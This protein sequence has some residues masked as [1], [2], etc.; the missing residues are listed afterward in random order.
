MQKRLYWSIFLLLLSVFS[1]GGSLVVAQ[2]INQVTQVGEISLPCAL[3]GFSDSSQ[4]IGIGDLLR[5][6]VSYPFRLINSPIAIAR[7]TPYWIRL[8]V[9]NST[10]QALPVLIEA[11]YPGLN[12]VNAYVTVNHQLVQS[13]P[14]ESWRTPF[15]QRA[16]VHRTFL[17]PVTVP[18]GQ[19]RTIYLRLQRQIGNIRF[20]IRVWPTAAYHQYDL[21]Q[22][23]F[24]GFVSGWLLLAISFGLFLGR[25]HHDR[26]YFMYSAYV[27]CSLLMLLISKGYLREYLVE[28]YWPD[29]GQFLRSLS[30]L[31]TAVSNL[32]F[33]RSLLQ[34]HQY[35]PHWLFQLSRWLLV[36]VG[37]CFVL[38]TFESRVLNHL[39]SEMITL[40]MHIS[41]LIILS[42]VLVTVGFILYGIRHPA[43][44]PSAGLY[45]LAFVPAFLGVNEFALN[46]LYVTIGL[47]DFLVFYALAVV[48]ETVI[49]LLGLAYRFKT[50]RDERER[51]LREQSQ[52]ALRTQL[53][54]RERLARD[55]HDHIGPDL[56]A[57]KLRLEVARDETTEPAV[58]QTLQR[59]IEQTDRIVADI[60]QVSHALMPTGLRQQ[61]L[62]ISL[63]DYVRQVNHTMNGPEINFTHELD[64]QLPELMQQTLL[65][66]AKELVNNAL[67]HARATVID[68]ELYREDNT[69]VLTVSDNGRG[70]NPKHINYQSGGIGLR[71]IRTVV[72]GLRGQTVVSAKPT[73]GMVHQVVIP[74]GAG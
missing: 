17:F 73:G 51:L 35:A 14:R 9:A 5:T 25:I 65:S 8:T 53:T 71:N 6:R 44:R 55:L 30:I 43:S 10:H 60:R 2:H 45:L 61:G 7:H 32:F 70:Y 23:I 12:S 46:L 58:D 67:R 21:R 62:V 74:A 4:T 15:S 50:Y 16:I 3:Y 64:T 26:L 37:C 31:L 22:Q 52:L 27:S 39:N 11:D 54:E 24:W 57:L 47:F 40:V 13:F 1:L 18:P 29:Y 34:S 38:Y 66:A 20:P 63:T 28:A 42:I 33:V 56:I 19:L 36:S 72:N 59:V 49:L 48:F 69:V 41:S 68:V